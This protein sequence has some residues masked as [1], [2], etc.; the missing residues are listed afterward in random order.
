MGQSA[1]KR[2]RRKW[3][4]KQGQQRKW[5]CSRHS[6]NL[7]VCRECSAA[8]VKGA[9]HIAHKRKPDPKPCVEK[10]HMAEGWPER[11]VSGLLCR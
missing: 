8:V 6:E 4:K 11:G 2:A 9:S 1:S 3:V 10:I 7:P 5:G